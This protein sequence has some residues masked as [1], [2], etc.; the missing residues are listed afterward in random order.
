LALR[1][2]KTLRLPSPLAQPSAQ[3][4]WALVQQRVE[5]ALVALRLDCRMQQGV[6]PT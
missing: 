5:L 3:P 1:E 2:L 6:A 4:A